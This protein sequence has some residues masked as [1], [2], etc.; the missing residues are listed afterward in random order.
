MPRNVKLA[1]HSASNVKLAAHSLARRGATGTFRELHRDFP[2]DND[3]DLHVG[4]APW[5]A[6]VAHGLRRLMEQRV[7]HILRTVTRGG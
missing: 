6:G 2:V 5:I 3:N 4:L 1:A 7:L